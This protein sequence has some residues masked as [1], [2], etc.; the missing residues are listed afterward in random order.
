M[1][2]AADGSLRFPLSGYENQLVFKKS[3][4]SYPPYRKQGA[5]TW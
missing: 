5:S 4:G 1:K 3:D 2:S